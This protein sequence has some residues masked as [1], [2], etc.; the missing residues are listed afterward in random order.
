MYKWCTILPCRCPCQINCYCLCTELL[1]LLRPIGFALGYLSLMRSD[2]FVLRCCDACSSCL[3][4]TTRRATPY[5][6]IVPC[7]FTIRFIDSL[8][9]RR[10]CSPN[11][12]FGSI[13]ISELSRSKKPFGITILWWKKKWQRAC[14]AFG[15]SKSLYIAASHVCSSLMW[16]KVCVFNW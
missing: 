15:G 13:W 4:L 6:L 5:I 9:S 3:K 14:G 16:E 8:I 12:W 7:T 2:A 10:L 1:L 11:R